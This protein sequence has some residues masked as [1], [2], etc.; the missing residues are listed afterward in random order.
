MQPHSTPHVD[1]HIEVD[2]AEFD[3]LRK[4]HP[5]YGERS[6][7]LRQLLADYVAEAGENSREAEPD[8]S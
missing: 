3:A 8:I 5:S 2:K 6:R 7:L 1:L 4:L